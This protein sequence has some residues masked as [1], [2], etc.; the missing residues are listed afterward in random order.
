MRDVSLFYIKSYVGIHSKIQSNF[1]GQ[2]IKKNTVRNYR[3]D[4]STSLTAN[5][6]VTFFVRM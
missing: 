4:I 3:T 5:S 6:V 2:D 1:I